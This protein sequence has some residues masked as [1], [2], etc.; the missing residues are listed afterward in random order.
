MPTDLPPAIVMDC[1]M[2][3]YISHQTEEDIRVR[4]TKDVHLDGRLCTWVTDILA[5]RTTF[6]PPRWRLSERLL[7]FMP[8][9]NY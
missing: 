4:R 3:L 9:A 8:T 6:L 2:C 1:D 5:P 7:Q